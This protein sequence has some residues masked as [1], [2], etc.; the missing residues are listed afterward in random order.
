MDDGGWILDQ[1]TPDEAPLFRTV[2][3][4]STRG[5]AQ[6]ETSEIQ[7]SLLLTSSMRRRCTSVGGGDGRQEVRASGS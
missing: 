5:A 3:P 4:N 7:V 6:G 2:S 1:L